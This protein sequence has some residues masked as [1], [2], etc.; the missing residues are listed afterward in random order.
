MLQSGV[1]IIA[2]WDSFDVLKSRVGVITN[3]YSFFA[4]QSKTSGII[5]WYSK[6]GNYNKVGHYNLLGNRAFSHENSREAELLKSQGRKSNTPTTNVF[7]SFWSLRNNP[8]EVFLEL[9]FVF[10][11]FFENF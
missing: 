11:Q 3:W 5:K 4:L 6:W 2:K 10:I 9:K 8:S 7:A 1:S